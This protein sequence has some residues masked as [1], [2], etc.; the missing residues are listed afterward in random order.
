[1]LGAAA[2]L[3]AG[4]LIAPKSGKRTREELANAAR[5]FPG[6]ARELVELSK[7]RF[8]EIKIKLQENRQHARA[9][10]AAGKGPDQ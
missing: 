10:A 6:K 1:M 7:D 3:A 9:E 2:G 8:D 4:L 5:Q